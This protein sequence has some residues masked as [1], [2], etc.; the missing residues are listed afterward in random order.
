MA[1]MSSYFR[2]EKVMWNG[3]GVGRKDHRMAKDP[4]LKSN[5]EIII[6]HIFIIKYS[7]LS[8]D[9]LIQPHR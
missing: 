3:V 9:L 4:K 1:F 7:D 6:C 2:Y 8:S 5:Q